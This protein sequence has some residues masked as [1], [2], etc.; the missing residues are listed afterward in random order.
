[1]SKES[2]KD[3]HFNNEFLLNFIMHLPNCI[4]FGDSSTFRIESDFTSYDDPPPWPSPD[5][6][7][8]YVKSFRKIF[9]GFFNCPP[10]GVQQ[11][12]SK[13]KTDILVKTGK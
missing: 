6:P 2:S 12:C 9:P 11:G 7:H 4:T 10:V 1:M 3:E 5:N 8:S 13:Y